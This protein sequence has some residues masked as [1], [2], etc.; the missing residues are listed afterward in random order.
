MQTNATEEFKAACHSL[1]DNHVRTDLVFARKLLFCRACLC[2]FHANDTKAAHPQ[3]Q[4]CLSR[5]LC[6]EYK[7]SSPESLTEALQKEATLLQEYMPGAVQLIPRFSSAHIEPSNPFQAQSDLSFGPDEHN[8][9]RWLQARVA[10]LEQQVKAAF[11]ETKDLAKDNER[12]KKE[13]EDL[14]ENLLNEKAK[15]EEVKMRA[16]LHL[17]EVMR[18]LQ[19]HPSQ[20]DEKNKKTNTK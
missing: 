9:V 6:T 15:H 17:K 10:M 7:V 1:W 8:Q 2:F 11:E 16:E 20:R 19:P 14:F 12:L 3:C 18:L 4:T 13:S 5:Q